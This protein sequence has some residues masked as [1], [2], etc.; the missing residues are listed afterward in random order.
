MSICIRPFSTNKHPIYIYARRRICRYRE[1]TR[2]PHFDG[3]QTHLFN[4][5]YRWKSY[6]YSYRAIFCLSVRERVWQLDALLCTEATYVDEGRRNYSQGRPTIK[7]YLC[8]TDACLLHLLNRRFRRCYRQTKWWEVD[9][10]VNTCCLG[11]KWDLILDRFI[12]ESF[13]E[14]EMPV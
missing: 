5:A 2:Q 13:G 4:D 9:F 3:K 8:T 7:P 11:L 14:D 10:N 1:A 12:Y 6:H